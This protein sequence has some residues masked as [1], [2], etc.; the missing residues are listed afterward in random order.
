MK[1]L[2]IDTETNGLPRG[3]RQPRMIQIGA[4]V[5][6]IPGDGDTLFEMDE[7]VDPEE[8]ESAWD[9]TSEVIHGIP[10]KHVIEAPP[11]F[12]FFPALANATVGCQA[13]IGYNVQYDTD[14]LG[15]E[16]DLIGMGRA[17]PWPPKIV[18]VQDL[19]R[20]H[21]PH[22]ESKKGVAPYKLSEAYEMVLGKPME[23][24]HDAMADIRQTI[25]LYLE[26]IR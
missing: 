22:K 26:L 4:L 20:N 11:F 1:F 15:N 14:V 17:F 23:D 2:G 7:I 24:A 8:A 10:R 3:T 13:I 9:E 12:H 21:L 5:L 25:E 19:A 16:I 6:E 18:D